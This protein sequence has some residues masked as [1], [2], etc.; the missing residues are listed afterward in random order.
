MVSAM[1]GNPPWAAI[2]PEIYAG[3]LASELALTQGSLDRALGPKGVNFIISIHRI[4]LLQ[5]HLTCPKDRARFQ[6][7]LAFLRQLCRHY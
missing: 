5:M 4:D 1:D 7:P 2:I 6:Q 3:I